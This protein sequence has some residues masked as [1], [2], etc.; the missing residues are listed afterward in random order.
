MSALALKMHSLDTLFDVQDS[1]GSGRSA[2]RWGF[3]EV[4]CVS[5]T[6][7]LIALLP[8]VTPAWKVLSSGYQLVGRDGARCQKPLGFHYVLV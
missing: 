8:C 2:R 3:F 4:V 7:P 6:S 1:K 5:L